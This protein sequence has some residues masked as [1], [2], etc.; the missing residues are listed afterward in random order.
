MDSN[1]FMTV[2]ELQFDT[3]KAVLA[4]KRAQY[5]PGID[6]LSNFRKAGH[7]QNETPIKALHGMMTKHTVGLADLVE[8][9]EAGDPTD[10]ADWL[11]YITDKINY[12]LLLRGLLEEVFSSVNDVDE[13]NSH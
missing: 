7:L 13:E 3:C 2:V 9:H 5:A 8:T 1:T 11:E 4:K 6:R 10:F 12:L